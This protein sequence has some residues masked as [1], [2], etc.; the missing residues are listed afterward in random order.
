MMTVLSYCAPTAIDFFLTALWGIRKKTVL[1]KELKIDSSAGTMPVLCDVE[2]CGEW[3]IMTT[4]KNGNDVS[5]LL[6]FP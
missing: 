6:D 2:F 4:M 5:N 1:R 3:F